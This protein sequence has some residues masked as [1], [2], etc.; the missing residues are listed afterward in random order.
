MALRP[1]RPLVHPN[2]QPVGEHSNAPVCIEPPAECFALIELLHL[3]GEPGNPGNRRDESCLPNVKSSNALNLKQKRGQAV[4]VGHESGM[5][6]DA[7]VGGGWGS[8]Y[9]NLKCSLW[10]LQSYIL[11]SRI[12]LSLHIVLLILRFANWLGI[13]KNT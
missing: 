2:I 5:M 6:E 11:F 4:D 1:R 12:I 8:D 7:A 13:G 10:L 9:T 3:R